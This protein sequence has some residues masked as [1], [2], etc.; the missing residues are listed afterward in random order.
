MLKPTVVSASKSSNTNEN[1]HQSDSSSNAPSSPT[2][3]KKRREHG[4]SP[5]SSN[6]GKSSKKSV[7][8]SVKEEMV[9]EDGLYYGEMENDEM[10]C[11]DN[12]SIT[13]L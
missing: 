13:L 6:D 7:D 1:A 10:E 4:A 5:E 11:G 2:V 8:V 3:S 9:E 12:V